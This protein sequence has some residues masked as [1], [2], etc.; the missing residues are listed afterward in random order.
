MCP[1][2]GTSYSASTTVAALA[3][4]LSGSPVTAGFWLDVGVALRM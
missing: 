4:A 3:S 2:N 1:W